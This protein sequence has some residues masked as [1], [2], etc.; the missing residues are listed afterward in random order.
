MNYEPTGHCPSNCGRTARPV[1]CLIFF[2]F[3]ILLLSFFL[4]F[5]FGGGGYSMVLG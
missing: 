4:F 2:Y 3:K 5:F 1:M